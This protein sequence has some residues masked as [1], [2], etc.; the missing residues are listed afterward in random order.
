MSVQKVRH[1]ILFYSFKF[2]I[3]DKSSSNLFMN[4]NVK[5]GQLH[6]EQSKVTFCHSCLVE[7]HIGLKAVIC[8]NL[9]YDRMNEKEK[10]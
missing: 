7:M 5:H 9:K 8:S 2:Y 4:F 6:L 10:L 1:S 3:F